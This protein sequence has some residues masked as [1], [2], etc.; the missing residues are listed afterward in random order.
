MA[1][2]AAELG[3]SRMTDLVWIHNTGFDGLSRHFN[4]ELTT[5]AIP[6]EK[7]VEKVCVCGGA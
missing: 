7:M 6:I 3:L 4:P 5:L 1:E 2:I